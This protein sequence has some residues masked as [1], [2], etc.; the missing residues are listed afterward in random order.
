MGSAKNQA[1]RSQED[2][3]SGVTELSA[4][5]LLMLPMEIRLPDQYG[6][7]QPARES[8]ESN[9]AVGWHPLRVLLVARL[10]SADCWR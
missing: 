4:R 10:S 8:L 1:R 5:N 2:E 6:A 9:L 3:V 7:Q